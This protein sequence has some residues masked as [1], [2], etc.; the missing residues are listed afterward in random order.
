MK[1]ETPY[2]D[3]NEA[4]ICDEEDIIM[5][6]FPAAPTSLITH[7]HEW[8][9][10]QSINNLCRVVGGIIILYIQLNRK[11]ISSFQVLRLTSSHQLSVEVTGCQY[12]SRAAGYGKNGVR[13][14]ISNRRQAD[15][16]CFQL[17]GSFHL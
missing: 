17:A 7:I 10:R 12:P 8:Q 16:D 3:E 1:Q 2:A 13:K 9:I 4:H 15:N 11:Q 5:S 6:V 14:C